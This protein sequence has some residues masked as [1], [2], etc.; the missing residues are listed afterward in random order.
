MRGSVLGY[1]DG[2]CICPETNE[3][4]NAYK[5]ISDNE[6]RKFTFINQTDVKK[7]AKCVLFANEKEYGVYFIICIVLY[8]IN[9]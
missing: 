1:C 5:S 6:T 9:F 2:V 7:R 3:S 4:K 8:Y